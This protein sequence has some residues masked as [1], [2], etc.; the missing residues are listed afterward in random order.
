MLLTRIHT[1]MRI[2]QASLV[3]VAFWEPRLLCN[4]IVVLVHLLTQRLKLK[5]LT[6]LLQCSCRLTVLIQKFFMMLRGEKL[7]ELSHLRPFFGFHRQ[8][9]HQSRTSAA[10]AA[11]TQT[12]ITAN[13]MLVLFS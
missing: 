5:C 13:G 3:D 12:Y 8:C 2:W 11:K 1:Y 7:E 6:N 4:H 9:C 10:H